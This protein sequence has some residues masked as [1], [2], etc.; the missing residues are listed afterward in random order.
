MKILFLSHTFMQ[1][2]FVV[3]SHH[4]AWQFAAAGHEV[5]HL[6]TPVTP[7][8]L[9]KN[10]L[11]RKRFRLSKNG[12]VKIEHNLFEYIP[13]TLMP[14]GSF[15]TKQRDLGLFFSYPRITKI[16]RENKSDKP[17]LV[18]IDQPSL[19]GVLSMIKPGFSI[20]RPTDIYPDMTKQ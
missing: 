19:V 10:E 4:L 15:R 9:I 12:L 20:Y 6:S 13:R 3:G 14:A 2:P 16:L 8:H 1:G 18:L 5:V 7:F 17:D 11:G